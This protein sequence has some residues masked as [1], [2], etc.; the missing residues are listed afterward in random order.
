MNTKCPYCESSKV[1]IA[2]IPEIYFNIRKFYWNRCIHCQLLFVLPYLSEDDLAI[3]YSTQY[4]DK[5]YFNKAENYL[6]QISLLKNYKQHSIVDYG[7][8]DGG[9][10]E[11]LSKH[12]YHTTG[13]EYNPD[14]IIKLSNTYRE[15]KFLTVEQ[16]WKNTTDKFEI[17]HLGD[18]LEHINEPVELLKRLKEKLT[19]NGFFFIE[20]PLETNFNLA[21]FFRKM[22]TALKRMINENKVR[23]EAPYHVSFSNYMNQKILFEHAGL[24]LIYFKTWEHAWP[25]KDRFKEIKSP[26]LFFQWIIVKISIAVS[27]IIPNWGNRFYY[28]GKPIA[29]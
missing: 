11:T 22:T 4:H 10:L 26:W 13:I 16:F 6:F 1:T 28:I 20:G 29:S 23:V 12:G 7:C 14:L 5:Y 19:P 15:I 24:E 3:L 2:D 21:Y 17:I 27:S 8:G 25:Y 9:F 18:V